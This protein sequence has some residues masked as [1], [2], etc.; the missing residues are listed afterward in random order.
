MKYL[1]TIHRLYKIWTVGGNNSDDDI[2]DQI[3]DEFLEIKASKLTTSVVLKTLLR[4]LFPDGQQHP[5]STGRLFVFGSYGPLDKGGSLRGGKFGTH[6]VSEPE[7]KAMVD[8]IFGDD[9]AAV[10]TEEGAEILSNSHRQE[11]LMKA[12]PMVKD[13]L[14]RNFSK[15]EVLLLCKDLPRDD[16]GGLS[17]H[18]L[19]AKILALRASRIE[20]CKLMTRKEEPKVEKRNKKRKESGKKWGEIEKIHDTEGFKIMNRLLHRNAYQITSVGDPGNPAIV[21]NVRILR[22]RYVCFKLKLK[23][24]FLY[25]NL[26]VNKTFEIKIF[27]TIHEGL[28]MEE[29]W[30]QDCCGRSNTMQTLYP[31]TNERIS[32]MREAK[33]GK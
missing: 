19:Q 22:E 31:F 24:L 7:L 16:V 32:K 17:F 20:K 8:E 12:P 2:D 6:R 26:Y 4:F 11:I 23:H 25:Q 9:V 27:L 33:H 30:D 21:Q 10:Y 18:D 1:S 14:S 29:S 13:F 15:S 3:I 5:R 28:E